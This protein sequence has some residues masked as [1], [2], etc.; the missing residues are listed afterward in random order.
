[1]TIN[2]STS[3]Q[4]QTLNCEPWTFS[5]YAMRHPLCSLRFLTGFTGFTG[6]LFTAPVKQKK[7]GFTGQAKTLRVVFGLVHFNFLFKKWKYP[8]ACGKVLA[9]RGDSVQSSNYRHQNSNKSQCPHSK[10]QKPKMKPGE[11]GKLNCLSSSLLLRK[12]KKS[13]KS[14]FICVPI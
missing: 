12:L 13:W 5:F 6:L 8:I 10:L 11:S 9:R 2:E 3:Q 4:P 1:M 7:P 14:V